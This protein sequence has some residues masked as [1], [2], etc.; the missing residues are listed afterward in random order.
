MAVT[1]PSGSLPA[2]LRPALGTAEHSAPVAAAAASAPARRH[3][4]QGDPAALRAWARRTRRFVAAL[5]FD[6]T[7]ADIVMDPL[8]ARPHPGALE[9]AAVLGRHDVRLAIVTG[10]PALLTVELAGLERIGAPVTV[11]GHYGAERYDTDTRRLT[12]P[13]R[14]PGVA[15]ARAEPASAPADGRLPTGVRLEDKGHSVAV[16]SREAADPRGTRQ[17]PHAFL[18]APAARHRLAVEVGRLVTELRPGGID[19]GQ[20]LAA[21]LDDL[22]RQDATGEPSVL[23]AGDD[24]GDIPAFRMPA[25]RRRNG[26]ADPVLVHSAPTDATEQ[27]PELATGCD[28]RVPGPRCDGRAHRARRGV[29]RLPPA[30]REPKAVIT[31]HSGGPARRSPRAA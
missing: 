14:R 19:K 9:A 24:R 6:G 29:R 10:R 26:T 5:D 4:P 27:V 21:Y 16:H 8:H 7:P 28:T 1:P 2:A 12:R 15:P 20:A 23:C 22:R 30:R 13:H 25:E 31:G 17:N 3:G 11:L 18:S